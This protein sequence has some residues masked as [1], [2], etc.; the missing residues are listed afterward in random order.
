MR[1]AHE[2][3]EICERPK[4]RIDRQKVLR[5]VTVIARFVVEL[6][7]EWRAD[8]DRRAAETLDVIKPSRHAAQRSALEALALVRIAAALRVLRVIR[9]MSLSVVEAIDQQLVN[10]L[11]A[12]VGR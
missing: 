3:L 7:L 12:P 4:P 1:F 8:P 11:I 5:A 10:D 2:S 9:T 6:V